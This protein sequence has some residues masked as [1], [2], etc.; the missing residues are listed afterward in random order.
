MKPKVRNRTYCCQRNGA[1]F[2]RSEGWGRR[3]GQGAVSGLLVTK[4]E[5]GNAMLEADIATRVA[6]DVKYRSSAAARE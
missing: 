5:T 1:L 3:S 6:A 2:N 4:M